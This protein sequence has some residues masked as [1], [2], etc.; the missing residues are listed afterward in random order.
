LAGEGM[1]AYSHYKRHMN[2][3]RTEA[4]DCSVRR[5]W[6]LSDWCYC[7]LIY[8]SVEWSVLFAHIARFV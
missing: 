4:R 3:P 8:E 6:A 2:C 1:K 5:A 7:V